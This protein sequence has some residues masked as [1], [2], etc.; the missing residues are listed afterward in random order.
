MA[1]EYWTGI[2]MVIIWSGVH[3]TLNKFT[4]Y[5]ILWTRLVKQ[6]GF[7]MATENL[8]TF[9]KTVHNI[10]LFKNKIDVKQGGVAKLEALSPYTIG[11]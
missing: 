7:Q 4:V 3:Y 2:Q 5:V 6:S 1:S 11:N 9:L 10:I 8:T